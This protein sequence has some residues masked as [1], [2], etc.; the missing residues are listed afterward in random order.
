[1]YILK[2]LPLLDNSGILVIKEKNGKKVH[3]EKSLV[4]Q[5]LSKHTIS[6]KKWL[7][8]WLTEYLFLHYNWLL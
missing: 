6:S 4:S 7:T 2:G 8:K 3:K 1:M 5:G